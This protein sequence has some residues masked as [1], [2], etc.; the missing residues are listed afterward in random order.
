MKKVAIVLCLI[1]ASVVTFA[2]AKVV[3]DAKGNY[4]VE[5][6]IK[7]ASEDSLLGK[8]MYLANGDEY[9]LYVTKNGKYY[10]K[11][12][13]KAGNEYKQYFKLDNSN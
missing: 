12:V 9:P 8:T 3:K 6:A 5:K 2:Q 11:R 1:L 7:I 4:K 10:I 13:S